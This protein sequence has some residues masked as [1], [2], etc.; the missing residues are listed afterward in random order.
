MKQKTSIVPFISLSLLSRRYVLVFL[1][2]NRNINRRFRLATS[3]GN[4]VQESFKT[5]VGELCYFIR[6]C[7]FSD[8]RFNRLLNLGHRLLQ[9]LPGVLI[10]FAAVAGVHKGN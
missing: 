3:S 5:L 2:K 1:Y 4:Q 8:A 10:P 7:R 6:Y 9:N